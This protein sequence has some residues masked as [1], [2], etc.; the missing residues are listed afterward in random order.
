[1]LPNKAKI[2]VESLPQLQRCHIAK[3]VTPAEIKIS[4]DLYNESL[5][6]AVLPERG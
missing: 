3:W 5:S 2:F 4:L 1:M 6:G